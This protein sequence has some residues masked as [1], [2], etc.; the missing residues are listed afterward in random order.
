MLCPDVKQ[1]DDFLENV[2]SSTI[3]EINKNRNDSKK[4]KWLYPFENRKRK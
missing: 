3:R 4:P 1:C 2:G